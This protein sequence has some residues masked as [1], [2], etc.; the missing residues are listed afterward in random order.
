MLKALA[1]VSLLGILNISKLTLAERRTRHAV[2]AQTLAL[3][4]PHAVIVN[5]GRGPLIDESVLVTALNLRTI[6]APYVNVLKQEPPALDNPLLSLDNALASPH[7]ASVATLMRSETRCR[8][9]LEVALVLQNNW[10]M[11]CFNPTVL[12][13]APFGRRQPYPMNR[14]PNR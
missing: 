1:C 2:N 14:G 12:P 8:V 11:S 6:A 3:M 13:R 7:V 9:G 5:T 4:Q 10:P